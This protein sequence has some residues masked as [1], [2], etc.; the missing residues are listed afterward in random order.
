G[1]VGLMGG[2][3]RLDFVVI[4]GSSLVVSL[5]ELFAKRFR[6]FFE[7][8]WIGL[9]RWLVLGEINAGV[10]PRSGLDRG[11]MIGSLV[12]GEEV[13]A[14][15]QTGVGEVLKGLRIALIHASEAT[16]FSLPPVKIA[17]MVFIGGHQ[18][19]FAEVIDHLDFVDY[20]D[21]KGQLGDPGGTV[22]L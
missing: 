17:V 16:K 20:L 11:D 5:V 22:G 12:V 10:K 18:F 4:D 8:E 2:S 13:S 6:Q 1:A 9:R 3:A 15:M 19:G 21:R 7:V 14:V